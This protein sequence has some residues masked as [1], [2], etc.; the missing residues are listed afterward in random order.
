M[1]ELLGDGGISTWGGYQKRKTGVLVPMSRW[2][3][4]DYDGSGEKDK[5]R[6]REV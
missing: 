6:S 4:S 1:A 3:Y 5:C 2:T